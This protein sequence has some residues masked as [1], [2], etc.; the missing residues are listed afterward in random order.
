[1]L[2]PQV[3]GLLV[4]ASPSILRLGLQPMSDSRAPIFCSGSVLCPALFLKWNIIPWTNWILD[5]YENW[6]FSLDFKGWPTT[7][8]LRPKPPSVIWC[9]LIP[10]SRW[11]LRCYGNKGC[12]NRLLS[13]GSDA[14]GESSQ[15]SIS[16]SCLIGRFMSVNVPHLGY[17]GLELD[18]VI[19]CK[20]CVFTDVQAYPP[21]PSFFF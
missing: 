7:W 2:R 8:F 12:E 4:T 17:T 9:R 19:K 18:G 3:P 10:C 14:C 11:A 20:L 21:W 5:F 6:W 13:P 15:C 16:Y 1:M